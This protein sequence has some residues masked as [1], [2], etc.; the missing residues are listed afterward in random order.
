MF[1]DMAHP[2]CCLP[3]LF[4]KSI[5]IIKCI[6]SFSE[7][8]MTSKGRKIMMEKNHKKIQ[9]GKSNEVN[10]RLHKTEL[11]GNVQLLDGSSLFYLHLSV[12]LQLFLHHN[13]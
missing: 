7:L 4:M 3:L 12:V 11:I 13:E 6:L 1:A 10:T 2:H 9:S 5:H 8:I